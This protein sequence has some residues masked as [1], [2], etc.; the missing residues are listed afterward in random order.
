[1]PDTEEEQAAAPLTLPPANLSPPKPLVVDDKLS[2]NWKQW[3]K[4]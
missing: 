2:T 3:K 1:M 4:V